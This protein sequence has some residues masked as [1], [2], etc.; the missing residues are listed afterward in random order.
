MKVL[1][2]PRGPLVAVGGCDC[3][4]LLCSSEEW[5]DVAAASD[6]LCDEIRHVD[7][8]GLGVDTFYLVLEAPLCSQQIPNLLVVDLHKAG[9]H[10]VRPA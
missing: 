6:L 8:G 3:P 10:L 4:I 7:V 9:L 1:I 2:L 5:V